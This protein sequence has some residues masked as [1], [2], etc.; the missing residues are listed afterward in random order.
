MGYAIV[1]TDNMTGTVDGSKLVTVRFHNG[2]EFADIQNGSIVKLD[3]LIEGEREV[4]KAVAPTVNEQLGKLVLVASPELMYDERNHNLD[5][6]T[7]EAGTNARGYIICSSNAFSITKEAFT[8]NT[9]TK[10]YEVPDMKTNKF[11]EVDGTT[12]YKRASEA[13]NARLE[14]IDI[15]IIDS[16]TFYVLRAI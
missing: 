12:A 16:K 9:E 3:S 7:N 5:E 11:I 1:R 10:E 14:L 4:W 8:Y 2:T 13:T 6:F 15:E